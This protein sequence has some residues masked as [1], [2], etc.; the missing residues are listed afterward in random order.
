MAACSCGLLND[1]GPGSRTT[2]SRHAPHD[3]QR[4]SSPTVP[5]A[6]QRRQRVASALIARLP[7]P[8][9]PAARQTLQRVRYSHEAMADMLLA[10]PWISQNEVAEHF[11]RTATW[12]SIVINSDAFQAYYSARKAE[13][14]DPELVLTINERFKAVT[15]RSLQVL[16]EKLEKSADLIPDT[17]VL[18]AA[19]LGAKALGVGGNAPPPAA[20]N[21]VEYLP[22][23]AERLLRLRGGGPAVDAVVINQ[24]E[25]SQ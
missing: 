6:G 5:R 11:G 17:R 13:L 3:V 23:I 20:P 12:I 18:R 4:W 10:N 14:I 9:T 1:A 8:R 7:S 15:V 24:V 21:P 19:E 22:A 16:Q 25:A 2:G